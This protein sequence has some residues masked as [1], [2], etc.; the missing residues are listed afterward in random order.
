MVVDLSEDAVDCD[1]DGDGDA[2]GK[3]EDQSLVQLTIHVVSAVGTQPGKLSR[4]FTDRKI[5][6]E[7]PVGLPSTKIPSSHLRM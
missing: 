2:E 1:G 5:D 3:V 6:P 4:P 7:R